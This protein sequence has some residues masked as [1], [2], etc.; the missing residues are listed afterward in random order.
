MSAILD[1]IT[2]GFLSFI[3]W[4]VEGLNG[5][6]FFVVFTR[7]I[8]YYIMLQL[9]TAF[10]PFIKRILNMLFFPFRWIHVYFHVMAA[11]EILKELDE[12]KET[13]DYD[14]LLD[15][16][17]LRASLISGLDISDE[18]PGLL[19]SFNRLE[20][21]KRVALAPSRF[22]SIIFIAYLLVSPV[23]LSNQILSIQLGAIIHLYFFIG[24]FAVLMPSLNDY[25]FVFHSLLISMNIPKKYFYVSIVIY[26][27]FIFDTLWRTKDFFISIASGTITF[28][29][30]LMG[31]FLV[32]YIAQGSKIKETKFY[33]VP[34]KSPKN[35]LLKKTDVEFLSL[36][37]LDL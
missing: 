26:L 37:D 6:D 8:T 36:E 17:N 15:S 22:A 31:L 1:T 33:W 7:Q 25:Y 18:N 19:M 3:S 2:N 21:A 10:F 24:I 27:V 34:I 16:G 20:Y 13:D 32:G 4:Y 29:L 5:P 30:Y 12:K 14:K 9:I 11:K 23:L 28:I 35:S